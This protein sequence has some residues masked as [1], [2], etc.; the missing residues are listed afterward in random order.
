MSDEITP[1][2]ESRLSAAMKRYRVAEWEA[3]EDLQNREDEMT[4][5]EIIEAF[6]DI[7]VIPPDEWDEEITGEEIINRYA[8]CPSHRRS[9]ARAE[10]TFS[11]V[12]Y[13][14]SAVRTAGSIGGRPGPSVVARIRAYSGPRSSPVTKSHTRRAR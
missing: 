10:P 9:S 4:D 13:S 11:R 14:Q 3:V 2:P 7:A 5:R 12:A 1:A 6:R 8:S